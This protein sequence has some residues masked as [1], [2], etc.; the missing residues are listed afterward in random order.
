MSLLE[1]VLDTA[2]QN[3]ASSYY[4]FQYIYSSLSFEAMHIVHLWLSV[5]SRGN[6]RVLIF[7]LSLPRC[8]LAS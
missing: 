1:V 5:I 7:L 8:L 2:K 6:N 4:Y 3:L